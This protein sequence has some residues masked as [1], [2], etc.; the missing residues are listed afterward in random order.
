MQITQKYLKERWNSELSILNKS[1]V[2][3]FKSGRSIKLIDLSKTEEGLTDLRGFSPTKNYREHLSNRGNK[4]KYVSSSITIKKQTFESLDFSF[5]DLEACHFV[6]CH[7]SN[8]NFYKTRFKSCHFYSCTFNNV[9]FES[10]DLGYCTMSKDIFDFSKNKN[11]LINVKFNKCNLSEFNLNKVDINNVNISNSTITM[12]I[13]T[14]SVDGLEVYGETKN[15]HFK[16]NKKLIN[17]K[18]ESE[19]VQNILYQGL[20]EEKNKYLVE[21]GTEYL[22]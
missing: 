20:K 7:F 5:S 15:L 9:I 6:K 14:C 1:I 10:T 2:S 8:S 4:V 11:K 21:Y 13:N 19:I 3:S 18:F 16:N 17:L 22:F 12:L